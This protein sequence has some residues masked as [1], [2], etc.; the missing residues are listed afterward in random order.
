M[1]VILGFAAL[2]LFVLGL[3]IC[4]QGLDQQDSFVFWC[5]VVFVIIAALFLVFH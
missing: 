4:V 1:L 5:G 3:V 2:V